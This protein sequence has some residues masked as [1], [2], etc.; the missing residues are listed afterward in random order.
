MQHI[1]V[2]RDSL[3]EALVTRSD[4]IYVD[5]TYGRGGHARALL[6]RLSEKARLF[7]I[8][9]DPAAVESANELS[10]IDG[11]VIPIHATFTK[12]PAAL[13]E[14]ELSSVSG[15]MLDVGVSSPQL[16]DPTRGFSF[17]E[18]GPLDMRM[19]PTKGLSVAD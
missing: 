13:E 8:D 9:R 18:N 16:D 1:P 3:I 12:I 17:K 11:R 19:D 7:V 5:A 15:V 6:G 2:L 14:F 10:N 4:G